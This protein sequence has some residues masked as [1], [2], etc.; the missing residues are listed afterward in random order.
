MEINLMYFY[1]ML[2]GHAVMFTVV[3]VIRRILERKEKEFVELE[4]ET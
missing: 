3:H 4:S 2:I 1:A